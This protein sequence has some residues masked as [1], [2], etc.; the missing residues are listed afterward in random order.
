MIAEEVLY[1]CVFNICLKY[2]IMLYSTVKISINHVFFYLCTKYN[3]ISNCFEGYCA[4]YNTLGARIQLHYNLKCSDV[5]PQCADQY[6]STDAYL[7]K[8]YIKYSRI[9]R[10][11]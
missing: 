6:I 8:S 2:Y 5:N 11:F 7:C 4:E 9:E 10:K 1:V 3:H